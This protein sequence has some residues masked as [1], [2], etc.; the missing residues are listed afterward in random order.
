MVKPRVNASL[1][2]PDPATCDQGPSHEACAIDFQLRSSISH[3]FRLLLH[4]NANIH[5]CVETK[6]GNDILLL[7]VTW[8]VLFQLSMTNFKV[9]GT[10]FLLERMKQLLVIRVLFQT[11][12][13]YS[14]L[15][16]IATVQK[17]CDLYLLLTLIDTVRILFNLLKSV[18]II[19]TYL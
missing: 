11:C 12:I 2:N 13:C 7:F 18:K 16:K 4:S 5:N 6:D 9:S 17:T 19:C 15:T 3:C 10:I 14:P 8:R 1:R